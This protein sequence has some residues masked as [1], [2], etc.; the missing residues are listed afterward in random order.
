MK[1]VFVLAC[2]CLCMAAAPQSPP[3]ALRQTR[4]P[5]T[6]ADGDRFAVKYAA[7]VG[8]TPVPAGQRRN[9]IKTVV[10]EAEINGYLRYRGKDVLPVGVVEP[11]V[12]TLGSGRL[13]GVATVDLDAVRLSKSRGMLDPVQLL[14]G[15]VPVTATGVLRSKDG[16]FRF[17]LESATVAGL[18]VPKSLLQEL[19]SYYTRSAANP[20]GYSLDAPF[21]LAGGIREITVESK[22]A[23]IIQ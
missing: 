18:E 9:P 16:E 19:V 12:F 6:E 10:T 1:P 5:F 21:A 22:R 13:S 2:A 23:V 4:L 15:R 14:R 3:E 7:V 17:D 11:Y 20:D 8:R